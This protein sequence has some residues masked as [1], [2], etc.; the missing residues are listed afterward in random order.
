M[1]WL[2]ERT[3]AGDDAGRPAC[4]RR[5]QGREASAIDVAAEYEPI[6]R[7]QLPVR[8]KLLMALW[9]VIEC[10]AFGLSPGCLVFWRRFLLRCFGGQIASTASVRR[11]SRI[12]CP[13]N[14]TMGPQ[15]SLG[16][17]S[18]ACC[19]APIV[20]GERACVGADVFL[21]T[22]G[23][24]PRDPAFGLTRRPIVVGPGAW[25]AT[26]CTVL[27]G[28]RIGALCVIGAGAVVSRDTPERT[29]CVGNPSRVVGLRR[30]RDASDGLG[31]HSDA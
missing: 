28:V 10:T 1:K 12:A 21:L 17:R 20:I 3:K 14:L 29:V 7:S 18:R 6:Q 15:S 31:L 9:R 23:H 5:M 11:T 24:D 22:G 26:R 2:E 13:W 16:E 8:V 4:E 27:P 25:L 19:L 30:W